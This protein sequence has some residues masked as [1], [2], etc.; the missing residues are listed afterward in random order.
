MFVGMDVAKNY[1]QVGVL[2]EKGEILSTSR[3]N[4]NPIKVNEFSR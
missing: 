2:D 3:V 1:L 4:N